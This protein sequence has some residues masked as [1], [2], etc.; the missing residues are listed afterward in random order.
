MAQGL[1]FFFCSIYICVRMHVFVCMV[2]ADASILVNV[3]C[4][5]WHSSCIHPRRSLGA[6]AVLGA[7]TSAPTPNLA[8]E[9]K[10]R[11][12]FFLLDRISLKI[13]QEYFTAFQKQTL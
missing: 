11:A 5:T 8:F 6:I 2:C 9:I 13:I 7:V 4:S 10:K 12:L 3:Y 1:E